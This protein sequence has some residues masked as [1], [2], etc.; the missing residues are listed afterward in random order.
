M[1]IGLTDISS[2]RIRHC[3]KTG[4]P[5]DRQVPPVVDEYIKTKG[6]YV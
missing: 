1:D 4:L 5:I 2:T 6:L 3:I